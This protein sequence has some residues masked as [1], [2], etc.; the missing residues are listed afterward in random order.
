MD[1]KVRFV[2]DVHKYFHGEQELI[3]V[4][5]FTHLFEP[6]K[7]W[8]KIA[9]KV[10][11]KQGKTQKEVLDLWELKR[12]KGSQAGTMVHKIKESEAL[13]G[14]RFLF[15][16]SELGIV[17]SEYEPTG[18]KLSLNIDEIEN[19]TTYPEL[20]IYDLD[21]RVCGQSDLVVIHNGSINIL[22]YKTDKSI[23]FKA[24][25][26]EWVE[27]EKL[28]RPLHHLDA[29]N[30]NIYSIKMSLYMYLLWKANKGRFKPGKILLMWT[31]IERDEE[32]IP[33]LYDASGAKVAENGTPRILFQKDIELPYRKKEVMTMLET[34]RK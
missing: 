19:D 4:S 1:K 12:N 2:E 7:D 17:E 25:S 6:E 20:M 23:E 27:P 15:E 34:R 22:D 31:P 32:G 24:F 29:C 10:A 33:V 18:D 21:F 8:K 14:G 3:S 30:G 11:K 28:K 5:G 13:S 9:A 16:N 26:S